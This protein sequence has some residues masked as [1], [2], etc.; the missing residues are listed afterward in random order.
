MATIDIRELDEEAI[1]K[2]IFGDSKLVFPPSRGD[3]AI[4][5][6][7]NLNS[8][9]GYI[10]FESDVGAGVSVRRKDVGNLIK[11]LQHAQTIWEGCV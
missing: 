5:I 11:A 8:A 2:I 4:G 7:I 1:D 9:H 6:S 10:F 3:T